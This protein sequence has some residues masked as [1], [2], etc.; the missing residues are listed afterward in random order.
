[1][2]AASRRGRMQS[3][4]V[5][6]MVIIQM[7]CEGLHGRFMSLCVVRRW[8]KR[9]LPLPFGLTSLSLRESVWLSPRRMAAHAP[10]MLS[11]KSCRSC[12][13]V[14]QSGRL[15]SSASVWPDPFH[16]APSTVRRNACAIATHLLW[17]EC[18]YR[19]TAC[20]GQC[21]WRR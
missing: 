11:P 20:A 18:G 1:M 10:L 17:E 7:R 9:F 3:P 13:Y 12:R 8:I 15:S 5:K 16:A 4:S 19:L 6:T 21:C 2:A 14:S